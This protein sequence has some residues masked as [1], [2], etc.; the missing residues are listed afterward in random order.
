MKEKTE[1]RKE[2]KN[3]KKESKEV[4]KIDAKSASQKTSVLTK[5]KNPEQK[6]KI[7]K[8]IHV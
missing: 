8:D 4:I 2:R 5:H 6:L 1:R 7:Q 3:W